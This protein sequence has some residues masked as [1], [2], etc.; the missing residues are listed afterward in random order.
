[1]TAQDLILKLLD[2]AV[3]TFKEFGLSDSEIKS[4]LN[5]SKTM[6][7]QLNLDDK[8]A[9]DELCKAVDDTTKTLTT[10]TDITLTAKEKATL[11]ELSFISM[12]R[13]MSMTQ[14][15]GSMIMVLLLLKYNFVKD[16]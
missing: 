9:V 1:M 4:G 2:G 16:K 8:D 15:F 7:K 5:K 10:N 14:N 13:T 3:K 11:D 6:L 12:K